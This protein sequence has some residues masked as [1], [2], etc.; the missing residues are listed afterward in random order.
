[1]PVLQQMGKYYKDQLQKMGKYY[2]VGWKR[3]LGKHLLLWMGWRKELLD[4]AS[5]SLYTHNHTLQY[6]YCYVE[7]DGIKHLKIHSHVFLILSL[8]IPMR[9]AFSPSLTIFILCNGVLGSFFSLVAEDVYADVHSSHSLQWHT[10]FF[11][12]TCCCS[13]VHRCR[14]LSE[15]HQ[16]CCQLH[17]G[18]WVPFS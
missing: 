7:I 4:H 14:L 10:W 3:P 17:G 2:K 11:L 18:I 9:R 6:A 16:D 15:G 12:L 1:M 13:R 5:L 8:C